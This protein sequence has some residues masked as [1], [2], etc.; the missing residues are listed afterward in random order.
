MAADVLDD[1][2]N[3]GPSTNTPR[4]HDTMTTIEA[5]SEHLAAVD[6]RILEVTHP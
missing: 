3:T 5:F 6:P 1:S 2:A 4:G